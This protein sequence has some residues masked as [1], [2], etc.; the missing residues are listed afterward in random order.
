M[1][2][3]NFSEFFLFFPFFFFFFLMKWLSLSLSLSIRSCLKILSSGFISEQLINCAFS[4]RFLS[5]H[6]IISSSFHSPPRVLFIRLKLLVMWHFSGK[7]TNLVTIAYVLFFR[8]NNVEKTWR[9]IMT[10]CFFLIKY[11]KGAIHCQGMYQFYLF[12]LFHTYF[13]NV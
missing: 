1:F 2:D 10:S 13:L 9:Y 8:N 5:D 11:K 7:Q 4:S 6:V 12:T 3:L